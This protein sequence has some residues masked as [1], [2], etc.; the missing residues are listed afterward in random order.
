MRMTIWGAVAAFLLAL[1]AFAEENAPL[2]YAWRQ[3]LDARRHKAG[4]TQSI[5]PPTSRS[6][7]S[8][9]VES[10]QKWEAW[11]RPVHRV[12]HVRATRATPAPTAGSRLP[13]RGRSTIPTRGAPSSPYQR[14][15]GIWKALMEA[16]QLGGPAA[17]CLHRAANSRTADWSPSNLSPA[18]RRSQKMRAVSDMPLKP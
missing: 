8:I 13:R 14:A 1:Q 9:A 7:G 12:E 2:A 6:R 17:A 5:S 4:V 11:R 16:N 10:L 18:R 15:R 3:S